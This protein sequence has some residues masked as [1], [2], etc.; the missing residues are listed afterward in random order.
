M[1][2]LKKKEIDFIYN[3]IKNNKILRNKFN[4]QGERPIH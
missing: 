1:G 4:Q 3:S 2:F